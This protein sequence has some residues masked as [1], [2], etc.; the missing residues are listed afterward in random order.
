MSTRELRKSLKEQEEKW[1]KTRKRTAAMRMNEI[2]HE[3][4]ERGEKP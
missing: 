3:L 4:R 2:R 1:K